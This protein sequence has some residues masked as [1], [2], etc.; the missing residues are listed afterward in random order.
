M[1]GGQW[2]AASRNGYNLRDAVSRCT[3]QVY[4]KSWTAIYVAL[5]NVGMWNL[6]SEYWVRQYLGQQ[7]YLRV[8]TTS[9]SL[10]DEYPIPKNALLCGR[11]SGRRTRPL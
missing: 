11:A 2:T 9:T 1:D 3:T 6:R 8:F 7:F 5:D 4:P 10:R